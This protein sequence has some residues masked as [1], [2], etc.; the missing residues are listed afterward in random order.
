MRVIDTHGSSLIKDA[1]Y[2]E[3]AQELV[4]VFKSGARW[5]Y[6]LDPAGADEFESAASKGQHFLQSI[7]GQAQER[8]L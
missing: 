5:A 3:D 7:K 8:R 4:L 1:A 2:D 6:S